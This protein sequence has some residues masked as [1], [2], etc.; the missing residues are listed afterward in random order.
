MVSVSGT[1][2]P[3]AAFTTISSRERSDRP[4]SARCRRRSGRSRLRRCPV[5]APGHRSVSNGSSAPLNRNEPTH[6]PPVNGPCCHRDPAPISASATS[7]PS[8]TNGWRPQSRSRSISAWPQ[9]FFSIERTTCP[10]NS[11][12]RSDGEGAP[13]ESPRHR[14]DPD[15]QPLT[16]TMTAACRSRIGNSVS[17]GAG[18]R[19]KMKRCT[20]AASC[21]L[22]ASTSTGAM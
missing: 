6:A 1:A 3:I 15:G 8:E 2:I 9:R 4:R 21:S 13:R 17:A 10:S 22:A 14:C 11:S 19:P 16:A 5:P 7:R 18:G 12:M 20:P